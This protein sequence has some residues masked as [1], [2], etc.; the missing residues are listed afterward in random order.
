[1]EEYIV[2]AVFI[3]W[4]VLAMVISENLG[5]KKRIGVEW[6][7]FVSFVFSPLVGYLVTRFSPD[8]R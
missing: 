8:K 4:Y 2:V 5:K 7:F 3:L 1:M 6:S